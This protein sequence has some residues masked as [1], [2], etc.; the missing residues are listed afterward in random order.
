MCFLTLAY[1]FAVNENLGAERRGTLSDLRFTAGSIFRVVLSFIIF[2]IITFI[3]YNVRMCTEFVLCE[4]NPY[5]QCRFGQR[6]RNK[7]SIR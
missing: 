4:K 3:F 1:F 5:S 6:F 7:S 2:V